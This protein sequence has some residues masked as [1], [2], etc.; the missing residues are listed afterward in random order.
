MG[1]KPRKLAIEFIEDISHDKLLGFS[2]KTGARIAEDDNYHLN[3]QTITT[4]K[5]RQYNIQVQASKNSPNRNVARIA[6]KMVPTLLVP[7]DMSMTPDEIREDL[8]NALNM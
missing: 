6:P 8:I 4:N 7:Y 1:K 3:M 2:S 5:P